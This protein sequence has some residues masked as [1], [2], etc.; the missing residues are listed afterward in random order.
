MNMLLNLPS[1]K[2]QKLFETETSRHHLEAT[3]N[4][5][6]PKLMSPWGKIRMKSQGTSVWW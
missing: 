5:M 6:Q 3:W 4:G 1:T 2:I